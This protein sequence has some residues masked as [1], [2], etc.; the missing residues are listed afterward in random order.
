MSMQ[1]GN[2]LLIIIVVVIIIIL[3]VGGFLFVQSQ[4]KEG[5]Q[6]PTTTTEKSQPTT[7]STESGNSQYPDLYKQANLP[8][9]S[10][11][12]LV[13]TGRQTTSIKDGLKL[14]LTS[15]ESIQTIAAYYE[16]EMKNLGWAIPEQKFPNDQV[17]NNQYTKGDLYYQVTLTKFPDETKITINY[18][19]N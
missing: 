3:G 11:A 19:E 7:T 10:K 9:Y 1:K 5:D 8:E 13:D 12:N 4:S 2:T 6:S 15:T 18:A 17:Y 16:G 14:Q